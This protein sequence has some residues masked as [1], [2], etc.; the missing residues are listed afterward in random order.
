MSVT[1]L[2]KRIGKSKENVVFYIEIKTF[3]TTS[4]D[5]LD[6]G[7][8]I[9]ILFERGDKHVCTK[10]KTVTEKKNGNFAVTFSEVLELNATLYQNSN[11]LYQEKLGKLTVRQTKAGKGGRQV[12][13][14]IGVAPL[15]LHTFMNDSKSQQQ[16]TLPLMWCMAD[17]ATLSINVSSRISNSTNN[18]EKS[19]DDDDSSI[20]STP[21]FLATIGTKNKTSFIHQC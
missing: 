15:Q 11:G 9:N 8:E 19:Q 5:G 12:Y 10:T 7:D 6:E 20:A 14:A 16:I 4:I 1:N 2:F 18:S 17:K 3:N 13:K 21:S